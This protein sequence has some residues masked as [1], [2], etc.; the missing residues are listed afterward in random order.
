[1]TVEGIHHDNFNADGKVDVELKPHLAQYYSAVVNV[2][3][4]DAVDDAIVEKALKDVKT[5]P[6]I[7]NLLPYFVTFVRTAI[8]KHA[9]KDA[10][11]AK[12]LRLLD[13]LCDNKF[14]NLSPKPYLSHL[15]TALLSVLIPATA[16]SLDHV[17]TASDV[18]VG[19]LRRWATPT[20]QLGLQTHNALKDFLLKKDV[21][22]ASAMSHFGALTALTKLGA[23]TIKE[24]LLPISAQYL[25]KLRSVED[26]RAF[27]LLYDALK[28]AFILVLAGKEAD[29]DVYIEAYEEFGDSVSAVG[30]KAFP[31]LQKF[32]RP[33]PDKEIVGRI[34]IKRIDDDESK[35]PPTKKSKKSRLSFDFK[36]TSRRYPPL[37]I[38]GNGIESRPEAE[39]KR[40]SFPHSSSSKCD[41]IPLIIGRRLGYPKTTERLK[42]IRLYSCSLLNTL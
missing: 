24:H 30:P 26:K 33:I 25:E 41:S 3:V 34:R 15:V 39:L 6:K 40:I 37:E 1:M 35:A 17:E 11:V 31:P 4:Q 5:N 16:A 23:E 28:F 19:V 22:S 29:E 18:L 38:K 42:T 13:A 2:L 9:E 32:H 20:N 27:R 10:L 36:K 8:Q 7:G 12:M 14:L 21:N